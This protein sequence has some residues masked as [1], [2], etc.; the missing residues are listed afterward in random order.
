MQVDIT[1]DTLFK[2][3]IITFFYIFLASEILSQTDGP[4][5]NLNNSCSQQ[6]NKAF[7]SLAIELFKQH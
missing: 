7:S 5:S 2:R 4:K 6:Y 3:D 1:A